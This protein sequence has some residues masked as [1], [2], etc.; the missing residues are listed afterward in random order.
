MTIHDKTLISGSKGGSS[1]GKGKGSSSGGGSSAS[2]TLRSKARARL[3]ELVGEGPNVGLVNGDASIYFEQTP[4]RNEGG[5]LNFQNVVWQ[6]RLGTPDQDYLTGFPTAEVPYDVNVEVK[7]A[8]G[9]V[10]RTIN[11]T[12]ADAVRVIINLPSL[13]EQDAKSGQLKTA[14]VAYALEVRGYGGSWQRT[15][16]VH[17]DNQK[18]TSAVQRAHRVPLPYGGCPWDIRV[19][20]LTADSA[21]ERL[22]NQTHFESYTVLIE[23][24]FSYPNSGIVAL[25]VNAEDMGQS[26]PARYYRWRGRIVLVPSNYDPINRT[27]S[28]IWNGTFKNAWTNNPAWIFYD[29]LTNNRYGLGEFLNVNTVDKWSLYSIAQYCDQAVK[30][31]FKNA[32]TGADI[33]EPRY[34]F[35]GVLKSR[36]DAYKVL[37]QITT[38]WRGMCYWSLGQVFATADMPADPVKLVTPANVIDGEFEYSGTSKKARHSVAIVTYNDPDDFYQPNVE[39]VINNSLLQRFGWREKSVDYLGCTS[40]GLAHRYGK[41]ILDIEENETETVEYSASWDHADVRPGDVI[42]VA[43]PRKAQIRL[44]GRLAG[45]GTNYLNLDFPFERVVGETYSIIVAL[46]SGKVQTVNIDSFAD[47][48]F[49]EGVSKGFTRVN[50]KAALTEQPMVNAM[51][52]IT[53]TD[54][55]PRLYRV[56][57]MSEEKKNIF[58]VTA[59]F[60]DPNKYARVEQDITLKPKTYTR[61]STTADTPTGLRIDES[62]FIA[63]GRTHQ[64]LTLSWSAGG[65]DWT[66]RSYEVGV[67]HPTKGY[68]VL[69]TTKGTSCDLDDPDVGDYTFLVSGVS[70]SSVRSVP[71][72]L[73]YHYAGFGNLPMPTVSD[74]HLTEHPGS[75][76]FTG[77]NASI[78][79]SNNFAQTT[80]QIA[81]GFLSADAVSPF[82][83]YNTVKVYRPSDGALLR[84]DR[85]FTPSYV[86]TYEMNRADNAAHGS[87]WPSRNLRFE[88]TV[89]DI[90]GRE[91]L[92]APLAVSNPPPPELAI[93]TAVN[94]R[95]I[96]IDWENPNLIDFAAVEVWVEKNGTYDP[97]AIKPYYEGTADRLV[98]PGEDATD[99]FIRIG[100]YDTFGKD[101]M[102]IAP[103]VQVHTE[104]LLDTQAPSV[105]TGLTLTTSI[106]TAPDGSLRATVSA[107]VTLNTE[108]DFARYDFQIKE[109]AGNYVTSSSGQP[110]YQWTVMPGRTYTV[111]VRALDIVN[112]PSVYCAEQSIVAA[113]DTTPPAIP[114]GLHATGLFRSVWVDCTP[115]SDSDLDFYEI[116]ASKA[117]LASIYPCA[118]PPFI[119]SNL[120]VGD[121]WSF[122]IRAVDTSNNR[123]DW[124]AP[125]SATVGAINPGELPADALISSFALIDTAFI[126]SAQIV[127]M[128]A[129]KLKAGSVI[130]GTVKVSTSAG[131][132]DLSNGGGLVNAGTTQIDPGKI[133]ISGT[134]TLADWRSGSDATEINGGVISANTIQ[135]NSLVIGQ[136]GVVVEGIEFSSNSPTV[137]NIAWS[138]GTIRYTDDDG[139]VASRNIAANFAVWTTGVLYL[140]W[141]KG[142]TT[143]LASPDAV[144]AFDPSNLVV[145]VYRGANDMVVDYGRTIIDGAKIQTGTIQADQ[146]A[147]NSI[148]ATH[149][150]ANSIDT[151]NLVANSINANKIQ[152]N[153]ITT[154]KLAAR[155]ITADKIAA[156]SLDATVIKAHSISTDLLTVGGVDINALAVG[157]CSGSAAAAAGD[158]IGC[159]AG[160]YTS[161]LAVAIAVPAGG[162]VQLWGSAAIAERETNLSDSIPCALYVWRNGAGIYGSQDYINQT[163]TVVTVSGSGGSNG[164]GQT[165]TYH[166]Y[167]GGMVNFC[168]VD[169][170]GAGTHTYQF[171]LLPQNF[172]VNVTMRALLATVFK[173]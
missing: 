146:I 105:P 35:N 74:V 61:P 156:G 97:T 106:D 79:W 172:T 131:N 5:S 92:S 107:T 48:V 57:A 11:E 26:I 33:Y 1:G 133:K 3:I 134:T 160:G 143:L 40:R 7:A 18:C 19:V 109:G 103:P 119:H 2:D 111:R 42:A 142:G 73:A 80:S 108:T 101:G 89:T 163:R 168:W 162:Y 83:S 75:P 120:T 87:A 27:Y 127:E 123:S 141:V 13:V 41:W 137:N 148:G 82:Y 151:N 167:C 66:T 56:I 43:D 53:G 110:N 147:A 77:P 157:A 64:R 69:A 128:D 62:S 84:T 58:K 9:P 173:R 99:Y 59:L 145:A 117:G 34:T 20:R 55:Q 51:W 21:N 116:E 124:S 15:E 67:I 39:V 38:A 118:A 4:V 129:G 112:N 36:D 159:G 126:E 81:A 8:T 153:A 91:S 6:Q 45:F 165:T 132:V 155:S 170:P 68:Y 54:I 70:Y 60:H 85:C 95:T 14:S 86:Y 144:T 96:Y 88:V 28:G 12:D 10:T 44:G 130:A 16:E 164:T 71:A 152:A 138:S 140:Y 22:Q 135:A 23:G 52:V 150:Q 115:N 90:Y 169:Y 24:K 78:T 29:L 50:L 94:G 63:D 125:V 30:S 93:E 158:T 49:E 98:F 171:L 154:D 166:N 102:L 100:A 76:I 121:S 114:T 149:M 46:P 72:S 122:R 31:G 139:N 32:D 65:T 25:E 37:Q 161:I 136:R 104:R 113:V 17:L 47:E